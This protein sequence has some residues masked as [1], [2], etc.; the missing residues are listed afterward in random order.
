MSTQTVQWDTLSDEKKTEVLRV[1]KNPVHRDR[2]ILKM[3]YSQ[4]PDEMKDRITKA[5]AKINSEII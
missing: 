5:I 2:A 3:K 1:L 4:F